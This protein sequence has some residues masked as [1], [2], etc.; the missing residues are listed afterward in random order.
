VGCQLGLQRYG[1]GMPMT[2]IANLQQN[3]GVP[4]PVGTQWG[5]LKQTAQVLAPV[6]AELQRLAAQSPLIHTDDTY[7]RVL[8][9]SKEMEVP[10]DAEEPDAESK[11][12]GV[13]T[14]GVVA[15][16]ADYD[17][18]LFFTG[19]QHAGE[20][21]RDL[22]R[23]RSPDLPTPIQMSDALSRNAPKEFATVLAN[24][25]CH[26]RRQFVE[27]VEHFPTECRQVLESFRQIY[28]FDAQ[29]KEHQLSPQ[30]RLE[31]HQTQS[32]PVME[33]LHTWIQTQLDT[34]QVEPNSG[35]GKAF[36][37]LLKHWQPLTLFLR[38][39]GAPL[40]NNICEQAL[41]RAIRHRRNSLFYKTVT[42]A[43]VGDLFMSLILTCQYC[44]A[45]A[46]E[47]LTALARNPQAVREHPGQWL[48]WNYPTALAQLNSS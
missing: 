41:K 38:L 40:D 42:G 29:T 36:K 24:C 9:L 47:Y 5:L 17:I 1:A 15:R 25:N 19:R 44:G 37:Y 34:R 32:G 10:P 7:M 43:W 21:L 48:P 33:S 45:N 6:F 8:A 13:F 14:T 3:F 28:H 2:R 16:T 22:L 30:A 26:G 46:F 4:L 27:I 11:R 12:T 23:Q 35:L 39:P 20:N 31:F 18:A